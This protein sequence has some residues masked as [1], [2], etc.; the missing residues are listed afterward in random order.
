MIVDSLKNSSLYWGICPRMEQAFKLLEGVDLASLPAGK[1]LLDG[2]EI[3]VNIMELEL[4]KQE[5]AKLEV[6]NK[7]ADIQILLVGEQ[8]GFGWSERAEICKPL[9]EFDELKDVQFYD[10][11]HQ[12]LFFIRKGQF[13]IL[14]PEDGHAPMIGEGYVKKA[15]VKVL[16]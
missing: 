11:E 14:M 15:I 6:H 13:T 1:H 7:Y 4:K 12:I 2:E 16:I 3:F 5:D 10:D 9:G 8:E